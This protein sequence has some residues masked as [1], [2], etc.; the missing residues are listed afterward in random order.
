MKFL[1]RDRSGLILPVSVDAVLRAFSRAKLPHA[2]F[3]TLEAG[4]EIQLDDGWRYRRAGD[5]DPHWCER[6]YHDP[7]VCGV[8]VM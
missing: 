1:M 5:P 8:T 7:C 2:V 4:T 6:C 3:R